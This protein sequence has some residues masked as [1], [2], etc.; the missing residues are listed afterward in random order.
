MEE[1][2]KDYVQMIA[3]VRELELNNPQLQRIVNCLRADE[4]L[5]DTFDSF[6]NDEIDKEV[7]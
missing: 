1:F 4:E 6:V 2:L 5:W 3:E 7:M